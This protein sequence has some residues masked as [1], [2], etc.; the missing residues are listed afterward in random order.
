MKTMPGKHRETSEQL[1]IITSIENGLFLILLLLDIKRVKQ[2]NV[3]KD[4]AP[5]VRRLF[6][7]F[8]IQYMSTNKKDLRYTY[9]LKFPHIY[10]KLS[11]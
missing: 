2:L 8:V 3:D 11:F 5:I 9:L 6:D 10:V 1:L 4:V 7:M